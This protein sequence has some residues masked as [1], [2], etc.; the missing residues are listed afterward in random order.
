[1]P[2]EVRVKHV[3]LEEETARRKGE[4]VQLLEPIHVA[5]ISF[6]ALLDCTWT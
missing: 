3:A 1:M 5:W 6:K 4:Q 2:A